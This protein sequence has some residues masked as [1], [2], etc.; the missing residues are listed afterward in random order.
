MNLEEIA[1]VLEEAKKNVKGIKRRSVSKDDNETTKTERLLELE[2]EEI[3]SEMIDN[4]KP[5]QIKDYDL[6]EFQIPVK[7]S[8]NYESSKREMLSKIMTFIEITQRKRFKSGCTA[9]AIPTT[10]RQNLMIWGYP[11]AITRAIEFMKT[12]GLI[13]IHDDTYRFGVPYEGA[14]YGKLYAY[15][16]ENEDKVIQ[17]CKDNH[18][19]KYVIKNVQTIK[20][21]EEVEKIEHINEIKPF[22]IAGVRFGKE[23]GLEKPQSVS[24]TDFEMYLTQCLYVNYPEF[25]F[26]QMKVDEINERFYLNYPEF[27]LR[28]RPHFT[29]KK[30]K[31][32]KIGI[33]LTNEYCSKEKEERKELLKQYGFHL[34]KDVKSS[35][36]RLTL[37]INEGHWIEEDVDIYE[38]I[39]KEFEPNSLFTFE[40]REIIKKYVLPIYFDEGSDQMLGKNI[41]Y[42]LG[43]I[44]IEKS[45]IDDTMG[46][47]RKALIKAVGGRTYGS[48][49]FYIESCVYLM[50]LYDLLT[51]GH[52][53]W[54][55]YDAFYSNGLEDE[56]TYK[57]M[58]SNS[59]KINFKYF[60]EKS[61]FRQFFKEDGAVNCDRE[62]K[63]LVKDIVKEMCLKYNLNINFD[64]K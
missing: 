40:R 14:N 60:M 49:I 38:L 1:K 27:K 51:S 15:Y 45:I 13:S 52:M 34:E 2:S 46:R 28:F 11:M 31:V 59:I 16:K 39:N 3:K 50:T 18:I 25:R 54:L 57:D 30:N 17:Y 22:D 53:V 42:K 5:Y 23:L 29:W 36:P 55:V 24:Y 48:D 37:S 58:V 10:S 35:V 19:D 62:N 56:E 26:H 9:I 32:E 7:K 12:I 4:W 61:D 43:K 41:I 20:T 64:D 47:L 33:R 63:R 44:E 6:P 8:N 21:K